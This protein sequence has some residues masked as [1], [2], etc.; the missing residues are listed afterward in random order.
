MGKTTERGFTL[1]ELMIT[2][3]II[4]IVLSFGLPNLSEF[5]KNS[6]ITST[7]NDLHGSFLLARSEAVRAK[8][9]ITIC[10]SANALDAAADC[11]GTF[12]DGWIVFIDSNGDLARAGGGE[13]VLRA[14]PPIPAD[15]DIVTNAGAT[16]FSFAPSGLGRGDVG[17]VPALQTA[18]ICDS[19]GN[20]VAAGGSSAARILVATPL[21]RAT[22]L[23]DVAQINAAGGCP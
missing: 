10:A 6:R 5:T 23:R 15:I 11:G 7:A 14:F 12:D 22:V 3:V 8:S 21:G 19:R 17:G 4:G 16:Y 1:Y 13:N 2:V 9:V 20:V 18:R